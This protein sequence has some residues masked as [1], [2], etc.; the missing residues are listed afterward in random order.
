VVRLSAYEFH[1][2]QCGECCTFL[3]GKYVFLS[4]LCE[5]LSKGSVNNA[6]DY[7]WIS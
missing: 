1:K 3:R 2:N 7:M 6:A 4:K 5:T